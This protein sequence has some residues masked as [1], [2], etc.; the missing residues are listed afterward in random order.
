MSSFPACTRVRCPRRIRRQSDGT[1][2]SSAMQERRPRSRACQLHVRNGERPA[3]SNAPSTALMRSAR[4]RRR[5][6]VLAESASSSVHRAS[7]C[8]R[9]RSRH[10]LPAIYP[11]IATSPQAGGL[12]ATEPRSCDAYRQRRPPTSIASSKAPSQPTCR[13]AA[14]QV[15]ARHQPEDRQG[16]RPRRAADAARRAPT[17]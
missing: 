17:R 3:R 1:G 14:D 6:I 10:Q 4:A 15:R 9:W 8:Q 7:D 16:A 2:N 11:A 5:L 12:M 13:S